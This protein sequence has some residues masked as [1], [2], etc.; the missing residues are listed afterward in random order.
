MQQRKSRG[1]DCRRGEV[2]TFHLVGT[3]KGIAGR[4]GRRATQQPHGRLAGLP[5]PLQFRPGK[6][7]DAWRLGGVSDVHCGG[8]VGE[9]ELSV[10]DQRHQIGQVGLA[11]KIDRAFPQG[12]D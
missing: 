1:D 12:R 8:V 7:D 2:E 6:Q 11:D 9:H 5:L 10:G 4:T 3:G